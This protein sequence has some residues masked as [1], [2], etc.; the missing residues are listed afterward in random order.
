MEI[1]NYKNLTKCKKFEFDIRTNEKPIA[2]LGAIDNKKILG[3]ET[4]KELLISFGLEIKKKDVVGKGRY[5][6]ARTT[7]L[8]KSSSKSILGSGVKNDKNI[9][10]EQ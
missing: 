1:G 7:S 10:D 2:F 6:P 9:L 3:N 5:N 8:V 4:S